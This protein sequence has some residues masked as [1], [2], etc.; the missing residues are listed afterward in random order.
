MLHTPSF[1]RAVPRP[2]PAAL[3]SALGPLTPQTYLALRR[4]AARL[5]V[6]DAAALIVENVTPPRFVPRSER[7]A[8]ARALIRQL[9]TPGVLARHVTTID[10]L[11]VA[12]PLDPN[13]YYQLAHEP[14]D[15]H[16]TVC[17]GCGCS[18]WDR[19]EGASGACACAISDLCSRG[20]VL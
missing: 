12:F 5:S 14:A 7:L 20:D 10:L 16:P 8:E 3:P 13:V 17:R 9:E 18:Q 2:V 15:R 6:D 19:S 1:G 4:R 11:A